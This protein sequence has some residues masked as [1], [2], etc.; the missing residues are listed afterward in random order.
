MEIKNRFGL[1]VQS[2]EFISI[3]N[4]IAHLL[5]YIEDWPDA[6]EGTSGYRSKNVHFCLLSVEYLYDRILKDKGFSQLESEYNQSFD[7][8]PLEQDAFDAMIDYDEKT[9]AKIVTMG[10]FLEIIKKTLEIKTP[11]G[12]TVGGIPDCDG[13]YFVICSP[14]A[15]QDP[16]HYNDGMIDMRVIS[17]FCLTVFTNVDGDTKTVGF[18]DN[19]FSPADLI[20]AYVSL[21]KPQ[22]NMDGEKEKYLDKFK[23]YLYECGCTKEDIE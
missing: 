15:P 13:Y 3:E 18:D 22:W 8:E 20:G 1:P 5:N 19:F 14:S 6:P 16:E 4:G 2:G 21:W 23:I 7:A 17:E 11:E 9:V 10:E 12:K